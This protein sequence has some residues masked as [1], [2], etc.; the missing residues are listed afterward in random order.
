[1]A[2]QDW[3][4]KKSELFTTFATAVNKQYEDKFDLN[5]EQINAQLEEL[6][7]SLPED[8]VDSLESN[9]EETTMHYLKAV[10]E[11]QSE[12]TQY[13]KKGA[14]LNYM[15]KLK[16]GKNMLKKK[17]ECG[18]EM[19]DGGKVCKCCGSTTLQKHQ[20]GGLIATLTKGVTG[21][22]QSKGITTKDWIGSAAQNTE[23]LNILKNSYKKG[24]KVVKGQK[25]LDT[26][27]TWEPDDLKGLS[28]GQNGSMNPKDWDKT[29]E[30][31]QHEK[32]KVL[33]KKEI[34]P[35]KKEYIKTVGKSV[36]IKKNANGTS[37]RPKSN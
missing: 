6:Y 19:E 20:Q 8:W 5:D 11:Q 4:P 23:L 2:K 29:K 28:K 21:N 14:K 26:D 17:C 13:A 27:E 37:T 16:K 35:V 1:M 3:S 7:D 22:K 18:C 24:G 15:K 33:P 34:K 36:L 31:I 9:P 12:E 25:G 32:S 10:Q 30:E